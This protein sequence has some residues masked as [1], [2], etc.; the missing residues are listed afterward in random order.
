MYVMNACVCVF[1]HE[2]QK[3]T[4]GIFLSNF[5]TYKNYTYL[6]TYFLYMYVWMCTVLHIHHVSLHVKLRSP[7]LVTA[8]LFLWFST[9]FFDGRFFTLLA[10]WVGISWWLG[11]YRVL[12]ISHSQNKSLLDFQ[13]PERNIKQNCDFCCRWFKE[14]FVVRH[15]V[16]C[17]SL[18]AREEDAGA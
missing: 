8:E 12:C 11:G 18:P 9:L 17:S 3:L 15:L 14:S 5:L 6:L 10:P 2:G 7:G 4:L 16:E 13:C 1:V